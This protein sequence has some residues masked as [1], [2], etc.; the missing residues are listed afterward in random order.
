[1]RDEN[2]LSSMRFLKVADKEFVCSEKDPSGLTRE[3]EEEMRRG[4]AYKGQRG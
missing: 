3:Q 1:M 2:G 4:D